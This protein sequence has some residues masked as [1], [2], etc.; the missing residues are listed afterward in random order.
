MS[1]LSRLEAKELVLLLDG[2]E[3]GRKAVERL[4]GH[5]VEVPR[6]GVHRRR[7]PGGE[8]DDLEEDLF[9]YGVLLVAPDAASFPNQLGVFHRSAFR[10]DCAGKD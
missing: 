5:H 1:L 2:D 3:A 6:L 8:L 4:A 7:R 10:R 9:G